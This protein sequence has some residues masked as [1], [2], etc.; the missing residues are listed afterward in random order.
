MSE[1]VNPPLEARNGHS[2]QVLLICGVSNPRPGGQT[3]QSNDDQAATFEAWVRERTDLPCEFTVLAGKGSGE[4]LDRDEVHKA[5]DFIESG[6]YDLVV[7]ED[8]GRI[9]RRDRA[10]EFCELC[11]DYDT[12]LIAPNDH[13]DTGSEG[14]R[15]AAFFA[16][17]R[18]ESYNADTTKRIRRTHRNRFMQGGVVMCLPYGYIKPPGCKSDAEVR[19]DPAA[20][21]VYD[22]WF[23]KL[24]DGASYAEIV[25]WLNDQG[26]PTGEFSRGKRW[27]RSTVKNLTFNPI[28]KGVRVR[29]R[30]KSKTN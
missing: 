8:P 15:L 5:E 27:N 21:P 30:K 25:D 23:Q 24:E 16:V 19:K 17:M 26:I 18:H 11:E 2:L 20:E 4:R 29:N 13:V 10:F 3:E 14:W 6:R 12:R 7:A 1:F 9:M 28:L 22:E